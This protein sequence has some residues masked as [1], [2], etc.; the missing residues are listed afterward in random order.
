MRFSNGVS[1]NENSKFCFPEFLNA[2]KALKKERRKKAR[3]RK[4][5]ELWFQTKLENILSVNYKQFMVKVT[6]MLNIS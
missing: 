4:L 3:E 5:P 2:N 1:R 6:F